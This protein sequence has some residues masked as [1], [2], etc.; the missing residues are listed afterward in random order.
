MFADLWLEMQSIWFLALFESKP[1][2]TTWEP[3]TTG[4]KKQQQ[5]TNAKNVFV[6]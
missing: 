1:A 5:Q 3:Y 6:T 2:T 4:L